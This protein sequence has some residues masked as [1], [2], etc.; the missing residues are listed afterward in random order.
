MMGKSL[1]TALESHGDLL[2][3]IDHLD[4]SG[5]QLEIDQGVQDLEVH[6]PGVQSLL[7]PIATFPGD[8]HH[9]V[10]REVEGIDTAES[11][12]ETEKAHVDNVVGL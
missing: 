1:D 8:T 6:V 7:D 11:D 3:G 12:R 9:V 2:P 4:E 10:G 5:A